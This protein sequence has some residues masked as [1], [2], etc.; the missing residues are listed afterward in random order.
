MT[1]PTVPAAQSGV[2]HYDR[3]SITFHWLTA[4][5]VVGL[6]A[7]AEIWSFLPRGTPTRRLLQSL[8]ISFGLALAAIF[9]LR[10]IWR[11][12]A[13]RRLPP[14]STGLLRVASTGVHGLLY[15]LL[16]TQ[17]VLG[18]LFR[19]AQAE[20]FAFFGLFDVPTLIQI[21]HEQR[22]FIGGLHDTV[23][24]IIIVL[25]AVHALAALF[26]HY[27]LRDGVLRRMLRS[28]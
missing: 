12:C 2:A 21:D 4:V 18:F 20:P 23:A 13:G 7:L 27:F 11:A 5:L 16:A 9:V 17:I 26:H 8:H 25:A 1:T 14:A 22:R 10:V 24:W 19:W 6:F 3:A 15:L 28:R